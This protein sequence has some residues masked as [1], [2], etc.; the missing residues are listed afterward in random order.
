MTMRL[1]AYGPVFILVSFFILQNFEVFRSIFNIR[2]N[3]NIIKNS[4]DS[5]YFKRLRKILRGDI[6]IKQKY[7]EAGIDIS[8]II[9]L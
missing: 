2:L 1:I 6:K 4:E 5:G 8:N 9:F 3:K 7:G